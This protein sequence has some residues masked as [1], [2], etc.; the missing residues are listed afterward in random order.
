VPRI[1]ALFSF[2]N[3]RGPLLWCPFSEVI[4]RWF[5][6]AEGLEA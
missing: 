2:G 6:L 3:R 5:P 1:A 4:H